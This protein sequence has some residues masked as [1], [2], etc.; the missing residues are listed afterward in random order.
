MGIADLPMTLDEAWE[1][2]AAIRRRQ[3]R[4]SA[5]GVILGDAL[6]KA[7]ERSVRFRAARGLPGAMIRWYVGDRVAEIIGVGKGP[8]ARFLFD[9]LRRF[10]G[11]LGLARQHSRAMRNLN[12]H[13]SAAILRTFLDA[14]RS[15]RPAFAL[16]RELDEQVKNAESHWHL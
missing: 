13:V 7:L 3:Q 6:V 5:D 4:P 11:V 14:N 10:L 16:P 1:L 8:R 9:P 12:R 2:T 15:D